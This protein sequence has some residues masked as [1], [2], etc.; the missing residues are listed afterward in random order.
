MGLKRSPLRD[1]PERRLAAVRPVIAAWPPRGAAASRERGRTGCAQSA[2]RAGRQPSA[3]LQL[4]TSLAACVLAVIALTT[5]TAGAAETPD[6]V[7]SVECS[8]LDAGTGRYNT[9]WGYKNQTKGPKNDLAIPVGASNRF[10]NPGANAGQPTVYKPG[11]AQ[12]VFVVAHQGSSTWTL[13]GYT[14]TAPGSPCKTNPVPIASASGWAPLATLAI[15]TALLGLV[16]FWRA[17]R[18]ATG[19]PGVMR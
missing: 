13:T 3:G 6:V 15:V 2:R 4:F 11:T 7:P 5:G 17:R 10:D 12:N 9:V 16:V 8:F 18:T 19:A 1:D 14:A